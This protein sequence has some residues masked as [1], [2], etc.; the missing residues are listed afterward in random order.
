ME[1]IG[2]SRP[3]ETAPRCRSVLGLPGKR[4]S[5]SI[6]QKPAA[7]GL[8]DFR[9]LGVILRILLG[10]NALGLLA[11][12]LLA[13]DLGRWLPTFIDLSFR[14]QP[15]LLL[16]VA[17]LAMA[18]NI[19]RA[20]PPLLAPALVV[21]VVVGIVLLIEDFWRF[22]GFAAGGTETLVRA[23]LLAAATSG[24]LLGYFALRARAAD[25]AATEARLAA[26][27]ARIRPHFLF[28]SLNAVLSLIRSDPRRAESALESLAELFRVL[29]RDPRDLSPLSDEIEL[30]RQY[31]EL[32][33]LR[34]GER[35]RVEWDIAEIPDDARLPSLIL[36]PLLENAVYHGIEP[37]ADGGTLHIRFARRDQR[38]LIELRNPLAGSGQHAPGNRMALANIRERLALRYDLEARLDVEEADGEYRVRIELPYREPKLEH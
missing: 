22:Y 13:P 11:A 20:L 4:V 38:L 14:L 8:P 19:L 30:C 17:L 26:L 3:P 36:Q 5:A 29:M 16:A 35:L 1:K 18:R 32:E 10:V 2:A 6:S 28:N 25:P 31:L 9:N 24:L 27:T 37:S 23:A 12:L 7:N 15:P 21:A 34:L 33:R